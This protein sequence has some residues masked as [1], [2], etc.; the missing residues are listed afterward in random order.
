MIFKTRGIV[1]RFTRYSETSI[2]VNIFTESFGLQSYIVNGVRSKGAKNKIAFYQP[3]NL[4]EME[5][6]HRENANIERIRE[7]RCFYPYRTLSSDIR[8]STIALFLNE[9]LN[10]C[11]KHESHT[12]EMFAFLA[13][14]LIAIDQ[15]GESSGVAH[16][17]F[18]IRLSRYLG[19]G[20]QFVNEI[21]GGR[22]A[23]SKTENFLD[24]LIHADIDTPIPSTSQQ[25]RLALDLLIRFY[26]DHIENLGEFKSVAVLRD[27][28]S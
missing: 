16:L 14:S 21:V 18:M 8:K 1:F 11:V 24:T 12:E 25:R 22:P 13:Q 5:V 9:L 27:V 10:K 26:G 20:P 4:L 28:L 2:I 7:V 15:L 6:Y 3:L 17:V 23:D 19:F